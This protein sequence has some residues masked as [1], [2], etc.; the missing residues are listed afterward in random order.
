MTDLPSSTSELRDAVIRFDAALS[1]LE[2]RL[3]SAIAAVS[4]IS[5]I[6]HSS[7][8]SAGDGDM[9]DESVFILREELAFAKTR[10][11]E[12]ENAIGSA[13]EALNDAINDIRQVV[14]SV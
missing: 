6:S 9:A 14:G 4:N 13:R 5:Q 8:T 12:L 1:N 11:K 2:A 10:E 7:V 3:H